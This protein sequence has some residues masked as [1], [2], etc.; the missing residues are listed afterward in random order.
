MPIYGQMDGHRSQ[1]LQLV[2][3]LQWHPAMRL[4]NAGLSNIVL[5]LAMI[6]A[7]RRSFA[8]ILRHGLGLAGSGA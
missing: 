6:V 2:G 1:C 3:W 4:Q 8:W 7:P 5:P